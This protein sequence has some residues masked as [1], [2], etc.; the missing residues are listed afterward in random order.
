V[1]RSL[2]F[3]AFLVLIAA[4]AGPKA[5][6]PGSAAATPTAN[7]TAEL[8]A[9]SLQTALASAERSTFK[10]EYSVSGTLQQAALSGR[11]VTYQ[12]PPRFR[13]DV[14]LTGPGEYGVTSFVG[15]EGIVMCGIGPKPPCQHPDAAA[16][17]RMLGSQALDSSAR[18]NP[19]FF[20]GA[21]RVPDRIAGF[22]VTCFVLQPRAGALTGTTASGEFCY[23]RDGL[24]LRLHARNANGDIELNAKIVLR[25]FSADDLVAPR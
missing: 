18:S 11:W 22:S 8:D 6:P 10:I 7:P 9:A 19:A 12:Q 21:D 2:V 3:A 20:A 1:V 24:P 23:T 16:A 14:L 5:E 15:P 17:S 13:Y 4:C 25:D